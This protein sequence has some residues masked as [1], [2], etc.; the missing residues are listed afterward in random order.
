MNKVFLFLFFLIQS[1]YVQAQFISAEIGIDGLTCSLCS[2]GVDNSLNK[3]DFVKEV[4]MDLNANIALVTFRPGKK[5]NINTL[6]SRVYSAGFSVR[7]VKA[8]F[9]FDSLQIGN[10]YSFL[11]EDDA[12]HFINTGKRILAGET[13]LVFIGKKFI[14]RKEYS[15]WIKIIA[16]D[17]KLHRNAKNTYLVTL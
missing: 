14:P 16:E 9:L 2:Y 13:T 15:R 6:A 5:V 7:F 11:Y 4:K 12:Y 10:N 3:L 1:A 8:V 17:N